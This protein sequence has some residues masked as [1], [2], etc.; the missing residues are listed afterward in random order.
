MPDGYTSEHAAT[1]QA[2]HAEKGA[3]I[4][5]KKKQMLAFCE[6][7]EKQLNR[8]IK[9]DSLITPKQF[10]DAYA[11][12]LR[13]TA[14][15][16][17]DHKEIAGDFISESHPQA[18]LLHDFIQHRSTE[19]SASDRAEITMAINHVVGRFHEIRA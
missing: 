14:R 1:S 2:A 3:E 4:Q 11:H 9:G 6:E 7:A 17:N 15:A 19:Y 12:P 18:D 8:L 10:E 16:I 5:E 13:F